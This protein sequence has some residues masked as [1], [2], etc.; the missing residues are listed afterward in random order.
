MTE[1][2]LEKHQVNQYGPLA[3][4]FYG[5]AVYELFVRQ[6]LL[7]EG[8]MPVSKLHKLSVEKVCAEYQAQAVKRIEPLLTEEELDLLRRGRNA[9]GVSVPKHST[10]AEYRA[11]TALE[12]LFGYLALSGKTERAR[13]LFEEIWKADSCKSLNK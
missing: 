11:A 3:L 8:N 2:V 13:L 4:A 7:L 9:S 1:T 5:D 10:V 6:K 12:Y